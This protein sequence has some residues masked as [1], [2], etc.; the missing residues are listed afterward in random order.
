MKKI[1]LL[2]DR[3]KRQTKYIQDANIN[4]SI[5]EEILDNITGSRYNEIKNDFETKISEIYMNYSVIIAH[6][7]ALKS[8]NKFTFL[9][10]F[11]ISKGLKFVLFSG[12]INYTSYNSNLL[13]LNSKDLYSKNLELFLK[14]KEENKE[15]N[16][17]LLAYGSKY[18]INIL[19]TLVEGLD[20]FIFTEFKNKITLD[21]Y[22]DLIKFLSIQEQI[23]V[24]LPNADEKG[25]CEISDLKEY[26]LMLKNTLI[27]KVSN[28]I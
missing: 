23:T 9:K 7:S 10:D 11:C 24:Q 13:F 18:K 25:W 28:V 5:Y 22:K 20:K 4:L 6:E 21:Q 17:A 16:L 3:I 1:L 8:I 12:G 27:Q 26:S 2:E 15:E 14:N 19:L